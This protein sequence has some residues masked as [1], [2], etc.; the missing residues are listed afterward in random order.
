MRQSH[1]LLIVASE[2]EPSSERIIAYL[3]GTYGVDINAATFQ[4]FRTPQDGELLARVFLLEP[5]QVRVSSEQKGPSKRR[6]NL[7][8]D[9]LAAIADEKGVAELYRLAVSR[10]ER[11]LQRSTTLSSISFAGDLDGGRRAILN[12]IPGESGP[13]GLRFQVYVPRLC[14]LFGFTTEA[15][16]ALLPEQRESWSYSQKLGPDYEGFQGFIRDRHEVERLAEALTAI[17]GRSP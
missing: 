10:F 3:S 6:P 2:I 1:R 16:L 9:E 5:E 4:Y 13:S 11:I 8:Y 14:R 15:A 7:T 12:L 17:S